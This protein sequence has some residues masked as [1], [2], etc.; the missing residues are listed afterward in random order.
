LTAP[1]TANFR[2]ASAD[3]SEMTSPYL[4]CDMYLVL[5]WM[6]RVKTPV[7]RSNQKMQKQKIE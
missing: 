2:I 5:S 1:V 4:C 3:E 7:F 6:M